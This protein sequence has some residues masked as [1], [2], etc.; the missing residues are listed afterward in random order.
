MTAERPT[1]RGK[2]LT[3]RTKPK[4]FQPVTDDGFEPTSLQDIHSREQDDRPHTA[5]NGTSAHKD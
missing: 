2:I 3:G 4:G 1:E 5:D